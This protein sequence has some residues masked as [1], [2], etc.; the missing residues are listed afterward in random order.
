MPSRLLFS[1]H[2]LGADSQNIF[3][4]TVGFV[5]HSVTKASSYDDKIGLLLLNLFSDST[6]VDMHEM[7][8]DISPL[9]GSVA[10]EA[11]DVSRHTTKNTVTTG[12]IWLC[13]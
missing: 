11:V 2:A 12:A 1:L 5:S 8:S 7:A 13:S 4:Q 3:L 6:P 10:D 9:Q